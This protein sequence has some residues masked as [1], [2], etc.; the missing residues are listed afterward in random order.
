MPSS[1]SPWSCPARARRRITAELRRRG[2]TINGKRVQRLM[3]EDNLLCLRRRVSRSF[4]SMI[5]P[6]GRVQRVRTTDS[7]HGLR[8]YPNLVPELQLTGLKQL[9]VAD[10]T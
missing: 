3:R 9:W 10:I 6:R 7:R 8:V 1:A 5:G 4:A 2:W